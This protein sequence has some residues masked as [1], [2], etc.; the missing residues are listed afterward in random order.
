MKHIYLILALSATALLA[1]AQNR[2][3]VNPAATGASTGLSWADA[4]TDLHAALALAQAGDEV[5]V[6]RGEYRPAA[7]DRNI[8][9]APKSGVRLLGGFAGTETDPGQRD[10]EANPAVLCGDIGA[11]S[12]STDNSYTVVYLHEPDSATV[13]DGFVVCHGNADY[14]GLSPSRDPR[15]CGGGLYVMGEDAEAYPAVRNCRFEHNT[16][17]NS[18][19]GACVN[20]G[21]D[22]SVAPLFFNC[23]FERNRSL[24]NGGGLAYLGAAWVERGVEIDSCAFVANSSG[25]RGGGLV[26]QDAERTDQLDI[27]RS[28]FLQNTAQLGGGG[29]HF[30]LGR[31]SG[32][33]LEIKESIFDSNQSTLGPA[34]ECLPF[35]FLSTDTIKINNCKFVNTVVF[36]LSGV[37]DISVLDHNNTVV[38]LKNNK[39]IFN[40]SKYNLYYF[41]LSNAVVCL[42]MEDIEK[43]DADLYIA[44][45][46][47]KTFLLKLS[48]AVSG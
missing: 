36:A 23:R 37:I 28:T 10:W 39:H 9:F 45:C 15:K 16:A 4:L 6:A 44:F 7:A 32:T 22:G 21:G 18:G 31:T 46:S 12:D 38:F 1:T 34:I 29:S 13:L 8:Y 19:G 26:Y 2:I 11:P 14:A 35:S 30:S 17:R 43:N 27:K 42:Y 41:G 47:C 3:Y 33:N 20:G 48:S 24:A 40:K 5:W 25:G